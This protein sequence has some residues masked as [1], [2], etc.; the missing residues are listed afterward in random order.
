MV[1]SDQ[2]EISP[3]LRADNVS[4]PA[5]PL[6]RLAPNH[7]SVAYPSALQIVYA[8][9]NGARKSNFYDAFVSIQR[10]LFN[11]RDRA[12]H[13]RKRKIVSHIF[14]PKS[15]LEFEPSVRE[16]VGLLIKQWDRFC[17][18]AKDGKQGDEGGGWKGRDG[19]VWL[20]CLPCKSPCEQHAGASVSLQA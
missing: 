8:H 13:A 12:A 6:V 20:D 5:G 19:R 18:G 11:T 4:F 15:V 16:Y 10:G 17:E 1:G 2:I 14:S 7:V 9:G 3:Q